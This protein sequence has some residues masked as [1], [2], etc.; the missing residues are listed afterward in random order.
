[1]LQK[2]PTCGKD[3]V[4]VY[5]DKDH[6]QFACENCVTPEK[7]PTCDVCDKPTNMCYYNSKGK[8]LGCR[9]CMNIHFADARDVF[10]KK[11]VAT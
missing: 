11:E 6:N 3:S 10:E 4:L 5:F 2:C 7:M 1:M 9:S 8:K